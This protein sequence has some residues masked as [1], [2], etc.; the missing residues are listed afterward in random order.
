MGYWLVMMTEEN[1]RYTV[2]N[3]VYGLPEGLGRLKEGIRPGDRLVVYI[4][5]RGCSELC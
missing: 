1:Y 4:V 3:G 5:K 2:E